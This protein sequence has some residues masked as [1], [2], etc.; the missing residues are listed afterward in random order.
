MLVAAEREL[1]EQHFHILSFEGKVRGEASI[2]TEW[3]GDGSLEEVL[4]G[5]RSECLSLGETVQLAV[6]VASAVAWLHADPEGAVLHLDIKSANVLVTRSGRAGRFRRARLADFDLAMRAEDARVESGR[7]LHSFSG[8]T[9][10]HAAPEV[11]PLPVFLEPE[12]VESW[13]HELGTHSDVYSMGCVLLELFARRTPWSGCQCMG[14]TVGGGEQKLL[15]ETMLMSKVHE[16]LAP[17][18][19]LHLSPDVPQRYRQRVS[20]LLGRCLA[21]EPSRRPS[22]AEVERELRELLQ[23]VLQQAESAQAR[24]LRL[25]S[26]DCAAALSDDAHSSWLSEAAA[27]KFEESEE[28][29][30]GSTA[31]LYMKRIVDL[32]QLPEASQEKEPLFDCRACERKLLATC[33]SQNQMKNRKEGER[34]CL[35]CLNR[36]L[37]CVSCKQR[38]LL[39]EFPGQAEQKNDESKCNNC[40]T[41]EATRSSV[42]AQRRRGSG[43]ESRPRSRGPSR[44]PGPSASSL[45]GGVARSVNL[46][47]RQQ[48]RFGVDRKVAM[49]H[50]FKANGTCVRGQSCKFSHGDVTEAASDIRPVAWSPN[51]CLDFVAGDCSRGAACRFSHHERKT[52]QLPPQAF[53]PSPRPRSRSRSPGPGTPTLSVSGSS[54]DQCGA[55]ARCVDYSCIRGHPRG[56]AGKCHYAE[57]CR[58][59]NCGYLHPPTRTSVTRILRCIYM[60][61]YIDIYI[62]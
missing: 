44:S 40:V 15:N 62:I 46:G 11:W 31:Q 20:E 54:K 32:S 33:F 39:T 7:K 47:S 10:T 29:L 30:A 41:L 22:A 50:D 53:R 17:P 38:K 21:F 42:A 19:R 49:C 59:S 51:A 1:Y 25:R 9:L 52:T 43:V 58:R 2:V 5:A 45:G 24:D 26:C 36:C 48:A 14:A 3:A 8:G 35:E 6:D 57:S 61:T 23:H 27:K 12:E 16:R 60:Y 56:R 37:V 13:P 34:T 55:G 4:F 18:E 28:K